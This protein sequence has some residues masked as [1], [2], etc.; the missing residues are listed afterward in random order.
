M[1]ESQSYD[2]CTE[3]KNLICLCMTSLMR[4]GTEG[5][6]AIGGYCHVWSL[7]IHIRDYSTALFTRPVVF[8]SNT[9]QTC[10]RVRARKI[11]GFH[12]A[13]WASNSQILLARALPRLPKFSISLII[14]DPKNGS[15]T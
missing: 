9:M 2:N 3:D 5:G 15:H 13:R 6:G 12:L 14:H 7:I 10:H 1:D 8:F 11:F 4:F